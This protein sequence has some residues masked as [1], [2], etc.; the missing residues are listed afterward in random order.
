[1]HSRVRRVLHLPGDTDIGSNA[2]ERI[3]KN[4]KS[5]AGAADPLVSRKIARSLAECDSAGPVFKLLCG[6]WFSRSLKTLILKSRHC[7]NS[8]L[9]CNLQRDL[10]RRNL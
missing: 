9:V 2:L 4:L 10:F 5:L 7:W 1:M 6:V 3:G 8:V